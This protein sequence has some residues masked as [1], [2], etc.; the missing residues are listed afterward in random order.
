M[1][2]DGTP[3]PWDNWIFTYNGD[4][5]YSIISLVEFP[6]NPFQIMAANH[7][8]DTETITVQLN[9]QNQ[10]QLVMPAEVEAKNANQLVTCRIMYLPAK[11]ASLLLDA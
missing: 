10:L 2:L 8:S 9:Q 5:M 7:V 4:M 3:T 1:H 11:Y 6:P